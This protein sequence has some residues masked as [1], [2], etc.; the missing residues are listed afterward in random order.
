MFVLLLIKQYQ[1]PKRYKAMQIEKEVCKKVAEGILIKCLR[2]KL[3]FISFY[4]N[5]LIMGN[6]GLH[7]AMLKHYYKI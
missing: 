5:N 3:K 6:Y 1:T 4:K 2:V 7:F